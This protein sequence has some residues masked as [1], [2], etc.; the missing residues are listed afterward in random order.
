MLHRNRNGASVP[1]SCRNHWKSWQGID[2]ASVH[3]GAYD[4]NVLGNAG[5]SEPP[6]TA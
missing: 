6:G 2:N 4:I 3:P 5:G 1:W